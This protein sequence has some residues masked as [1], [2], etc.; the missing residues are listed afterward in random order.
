[1]D[2]RGRR[3]KKKRRE[4]KRKGAALCIRVQVSVTFFMLGSLGL[5]VEGWGLGVVG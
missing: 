2:K 3:K 1:M 5:R 4:K